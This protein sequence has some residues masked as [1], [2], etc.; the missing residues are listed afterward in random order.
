[1]QS[2]AAYSFETTVDD[3]SARLGALDSLIDSWLER[4]GAESPY[5]ADGFFVKNRRWYWPVLTPPCPKPP[6]F[7]A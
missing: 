4:K 1:M 3:P 7:A 6:W 5:S 2:L